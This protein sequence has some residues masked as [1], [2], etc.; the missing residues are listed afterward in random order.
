MNRSV[1]RN[2]DAMRIQGTAPTAIANALGVSVN[3]VKSHIRRHPVIPGTLNCL[4][5]GK[6]V[7]QTQGRKPKKFCSDRCRIRYWNQ[8][9]RENQYE[10]N[11]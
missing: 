3:T 8:K 7:A 1:I 9:Y 5:C 10:R 6:P 11:T 2:I 4:C